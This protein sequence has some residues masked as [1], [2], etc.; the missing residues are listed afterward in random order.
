LLAKAIS[1]TAIASSPQHKSWPVMPAAVFLLDAIATHDA[2]KG[3]VPDPT[4]AESI[5]TRDLMRLL[6][7]IERI[8]SQELTGLEQTT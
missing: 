7:V 4:V 2:A 5:L 3:I 1:V 8:E 6:G